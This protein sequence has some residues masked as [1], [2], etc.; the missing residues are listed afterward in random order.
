MWQKPCRPRCI[1]CHHP[2]KRIDSTLKY[3]PIL[4]LISDLIHRQSAPPLFSK[5]MSTDIHFHSACISSDG[6]DLS[7]VP[8]CLSANTHRGEDH[9]TLSGWQTDGVEDTFLIIFHV[10]ICFFF[11]VAS[12]RQITRVVGGSHFLHFWPCAVV[13]SNTMLN[14][15]FYGLWQQKMDRAGSTVCVKEWK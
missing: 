10:Y 4:P 8:A 2:T 14:L 1:K 7:K 12:C 11:Y 13:P 15:P 6:C 3:A 5:S 9:L